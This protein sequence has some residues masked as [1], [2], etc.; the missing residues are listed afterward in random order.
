MISTAS[1]TGI[2]S[3]WTIS[4]RPRKES[5]PGNGP[6]QISVA[7]CPPMNGIDIATE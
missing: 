5:L 3:T 1:A 4:R 6:P 2:S 7:S